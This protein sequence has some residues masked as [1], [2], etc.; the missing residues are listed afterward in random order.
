M[1]RIL[2][3]LISAYQL[4]LRPV[5]GGSC[6]FI[7]SCSEYTKEAISRHGALKGIGLGVWRILRC[8]PW[9]AG[10]YDPVPEQK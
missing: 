2:I 1:R 5:F 9:N 10:G 4:I 3:A 8:N 7:P 6:R